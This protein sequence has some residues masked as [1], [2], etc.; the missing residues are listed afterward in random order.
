LLVPFTG[1]HPGLPHG[2]PDSAARV[3]RRALAIWPRLDHRA[4]HRCE[5]DPARI[6]VQVAHRTKMSPRAIEKLISDR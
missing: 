5:G 3:E 2:R 6:A 1:L 4:L